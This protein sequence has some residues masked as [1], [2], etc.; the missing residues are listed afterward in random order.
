MG[1]KKWHGFEGFGNEKKVAK[2]R[3]RLKAATSFRALET[4]LR[5]FR[6]PCDSAG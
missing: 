2:N 6:N 5:K 4:G 3:V 1:D